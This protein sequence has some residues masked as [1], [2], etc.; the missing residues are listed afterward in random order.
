[1]DPFNALPSSRVYRG[2][3]VALLIGTVFAVWLLVRPGDTDA[4]VPPAGLVGVLPSTT[5]VAAVT[6]TSVAEGTQ[7]PGTPGPA[8]TQAPPV[9][10]TPTQAPPAPTPTTRAYTVVSG[11]TL[12]IIANR[13][14]PQDVAVNDYLARIYQANPGL[15]P[16]SVLSVGQTITL[17]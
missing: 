15:G 4:G 5:V 17:P 10:A 12:T 6:T 14:R 1:M 7:P 11:D 9:A 13:E 16:T 3:L 8:P 2:S